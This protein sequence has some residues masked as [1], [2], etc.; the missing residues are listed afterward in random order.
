MNKLPQIFL[1]SLISLGLLA[2]LQRETEPITQT[3]PVVEAVPT[4]VPSTN[5]PIVTVPDIPTAVPVTAPAVLTAVPTDAPPTETPLPTHTPTPVP[6]I[7]TT[8]QLETIVPTGQLFRPVYLTHAFDERLFVVEQAGT[9]RIIENGKLLAEPFLDIQD[10]V[11]SDAN[12]QGL[13]S[14]AFHPDYG[15]NGR[16]FVNY[17]NRGGSTVIARYQL[18]P[19]NPNKAQND[20][21]IIL[22]TIGQPYNNHNGGQIQFGPDGYLYIGMGDGGA[23]DDP[24][25]NGQNPATLLGTLLRIDINYEDGINFYAVPS[26]NPFINNDNGRNEIWAI[27]LRNPW[28]FSF[29]R[30][31]GD[32]FIA[33]VGQNIYEEVHF[34]PAS[35]TGGEN[36]GWNIM[37]GNHCF[38]RGTCETAGLELPIFEYDHGS[39]CSI[40]GGYIYRGEA[41]PTLWGNYFAADYCSGNIWSLVPQ[42]DGT[43]ISTL[44]ANA[45][46]Q[47]SSFGE[48]AHGELYLLGHANGTVMRIRP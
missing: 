2:C 10:R 3:P 38:K 8:I 1:C 42:A 30:Q 27:G 22:L 6:L 47:I 31:T 20:S 14:V 44:T 26:T 12:E 15:T 4:A 17:T 35:S 23:A 34:Q 5:P 39:G 33:D 21:E 13:L 11:G 28:R 43:W 29:D 24:Q 41:F 9:I 32:L 36:Y 37:E 7:L 40:T 18:N 19:T 46:T 48:D 16:F 45:G 25:N